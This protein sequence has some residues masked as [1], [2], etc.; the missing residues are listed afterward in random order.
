MSSR[1]I[2]ARIYDR[3]ES[4]LHLLWRRQELSSKISMSKRIFC[5]SLIGLCCCAHSLSAGQ[6]QETAASVATPLVL[7]GDIQAIQNH[8]YVEAPFTVPP[9]IQRVTLTF[10]YTGKE[11][12]TTLDLGLEDPT[13]LRCWSGGNKQVL[14]VGASDATPSCLPGPIPP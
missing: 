13:G 7:R 14:T 5:I 12:H 9:G 4:Q 2:T 10:S 1:G 6:Q 3:G 8:S 11:Q